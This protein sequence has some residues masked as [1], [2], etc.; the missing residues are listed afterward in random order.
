[1]GVI[2]EKTRDEV[3]ALGWKIKEM[4]ADMRIFS[5]TMKSRYAEKAHQCPPCKNIEETT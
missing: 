3:K 2:E 1:M 4:S 5:L